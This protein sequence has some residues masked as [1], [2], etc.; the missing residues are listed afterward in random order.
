MKKYFFLYGLFLLN[1]INLHAQVSVNV[2]VPAWGPAVTTE[3]YYYLPDIDSYYDIRHEQYIYVDKGVWIR[4]RALPSR[5]R[6]Y[7][8]KTGHVVIVN[9]YHGPSPYLHYKNHKVKY[10]SNGNRGRGNGKSQGN[11]GNGK[12]KQNKKE[13]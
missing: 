3:E 10:F 11:N 4:S 2:A 8:L 13:K 1:H 6:N 7:N 12:G 5:Y 9:D